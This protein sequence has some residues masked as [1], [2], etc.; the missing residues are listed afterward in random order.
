MIVS[1]PKSQSVFA[2]SL[3]LI[4]ILGV[5]IWIILDLVRYPESYFI[6]KLIMAPV[7]LVIW[8]YIVVNFYSSSKIIE[9]GDN[10]ISFK[11]PLQSKK[12]Y[13]INDIRNWKEEKVKTKGN[14][15]KE[16]QIN[17]PNDRLRISNREHTSYED[18]R[19]YLTK[20][21]KRK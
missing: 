18:V 19:K 13:K 8:T 9:L 5:T 1:K 4:I 2:L 7:L 20:K 3:F 10:K 21:V 6:L 14:E 17:L 11:L 12:S 16:I 15:F